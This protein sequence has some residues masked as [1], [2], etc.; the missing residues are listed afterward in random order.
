MW[1]WGIS[2]KAA[3]V[4]LALAVA[5][6]APAS[7]KVFLTLDEALELFWAEARKVPALW[8]I[9]KIN[10]RRLLSNLR[11]AFRQLGRSPGGT[12][13]RGRAGGET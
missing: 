10:E 5:A 8:R 3:L 12:I 2:S 6:A 9:Q 11:H 1:R 4:A 7:S 13:R